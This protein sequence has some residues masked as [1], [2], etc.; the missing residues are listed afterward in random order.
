MID[1]NPVIEQVLPEDGGLLVFGV[2]MVRAA[3]DVFMRSGPPSY[4]TGRGTWRGRGS[5]D[6]RAGALGGTDP[7]DGA[8]ALVGAQHRW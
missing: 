8:A 2:V 5:A 1:V 7:G 3:V 4:A 6:E